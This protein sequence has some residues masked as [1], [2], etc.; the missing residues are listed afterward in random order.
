MFS[1]YTRKLV[2]K[3]LERLCCYADDLFQFGIDTGFLSEHSSDIKIQASSLELLESQLKDKKKR[4]VVLLGSSLHDSLN[5]QQLLSDIGKHCSRH[6][7][8]T[9][10]LY[11]PYYK[12]VHYLL[13]KF[14]GETPP[15][16]F[17]NKAE[18]DNLAKISGFTVVRYRPVVHFPFNLFGLG[19]FLNKLLSVIPGFHFLALFKIAVLRPVIL[20]KNLPSLSIVIPARNER[21]NIE[22]ALKQMPDFGGAALEII[23]VEGHSNDGTWQEIQRVKDLYLDRFSIKIFQQ[24]GIGKADAVRLG[25]RQAE[26]ELLTILDADL[27]TPPELL[28]RFYEAYCRGDGDFINGNRLLYPIEGKGMRLINRIG[29]HFFAGA[30]SY[31]LD[32]KVG[33]SLCGT[34]LFAK[35]DYQRMQEWRDDFGDLD[36][37]GDFELLFPAATLGLGIVD[38]PIRYLDRTYGSTS[39]H[40]FSHGFMLLKMCYLALTKIKAS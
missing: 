29:N 11:N 16:T 24:N 27:T 28:P 6:T 2:A 22:N 13:A 1:K 9:A 25:F 17:I 34:K 7:R 39:I 37:F 10:V 21:D 36:P 5:I 35:R 26:S 38:I 32:T 20:K 3:E 31:L 33:D 19:A 40:R 8:L 15:T 14:K 23:F 30:L 4:N 18:L 12:V